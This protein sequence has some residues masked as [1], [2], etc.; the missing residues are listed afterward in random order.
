[1]RKVH[2][3]LLLFALDPF[4][5]RPCFCAKYVE[6]WRFNQEQKQKPDNFTWDCAHLG[7]VRD[8]W[9]K[10]CDLPCCV[11]YCCPGAVSPL[12]QELGRVVRPRRALRRKCTCTGWHLTILKRKR[13]E[14]EYLLRSTSILVEV[15][16]KTQRT[17]RK[18]QWRPFYLQQ[19]A[20]VVFWHDNFAGKMPQSSTVTSLARWM[21]VRHLQSLAKPWH[22]SHILL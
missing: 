11:T 10:T 13:K 12:G 3:S 6:C 18:L 21:R 22:I 14:T 1:M 20:D 15:L 16:K 8:L 17:S 2:L 9:K 7:P 4:S 5:G 19:G